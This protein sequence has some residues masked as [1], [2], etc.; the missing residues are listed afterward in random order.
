LE[1]TPE[2]EKDAE[3]EAGGSV[4]DME[5]SDRTGGAGDGGAEGKIGKVFSIQR[6]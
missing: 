6:S 2:I 4:S 1:K 5:R 3:A